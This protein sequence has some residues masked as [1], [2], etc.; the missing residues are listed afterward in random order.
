MAIK[1]VD[2]LISHMIYHHEG[3]GVYCGNTERTFV[4][5]KGSFSTVQHG[6]VPE[7]RSWDTNSGIKM[8]AIAEIDEDDKKLIEADPTYEH[9]FELFGYSIE[10]ERVVSFYSNVAIISVRSIVCVS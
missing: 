10:T 3:E 8:K 5:S 9:T 4:G 7:D 1:V 2:F 6:K